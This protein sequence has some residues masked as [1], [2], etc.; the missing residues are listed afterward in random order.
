MD[1]YIELPLVE[2][3]NCKNIFYAGDNKV[4]IKPGTLIILGSKKIIKICHLCQ[5]A[6][7]AEGRK[8]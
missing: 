8:V 6:N 1:N 2:C 7:R 3:R 5:E 4:E